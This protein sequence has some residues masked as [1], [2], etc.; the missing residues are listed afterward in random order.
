MA[1]RIVSPGVFTRE[2]DLSF[3]PTG[4]A[5]I[6]AA[7]VGPT[8]KGPS[9]VPTQVTSLSEFESIFGG[10]S[11]D[12]YTPYTV[13]EYLRSAGSV[14]VVRVGYLGGYKVSGFNLVISAS[15]VPATAG[16]HGVVATFL[17]AIN[18][19]G[20]SISGSLGSPTG[21]AAA[22]AGQASA[23]NFNLTINGA[24][25]T[26]SLSNLTIMES[27]TGVSGNF[28]AEKIPNLPTAKKIGTTDAPAYIYKH[29]RSNI[30]SSQ[31]RITNSGSLKIENFTL[32]AGYDFKSGAETITENNNSIDITITGNSD[33]SAAR[34]PHIQDQNGTNLFKI[35]TRADGTATNNHYVMIRDVKKPSN[36]NSSP[37]F[38][39]FGLQ[40]YDLSG[41]LMESFNKLNLD[42][43]S[44]N[45]IA[46]VIGDQFQD[47]DN[48]GNVTMYGNY[49]NLARH[50]RVGD[51]DEE[52]FKSSKSSQPMG[53]AAVL[54]VVKSTA[55]VPSASF[56]LKQV[57]G[58]VDVNTYVEECAYGFKI[59]ERFHLLSSL[60]TNKAFLAP[61]PKSE[62]SGNNTA[63]SLLNMK[64]F[65]TDT[66]SPSLTTLQSENT[67][68]AGATINL[69]ISSSVK[70]MKFAVPF[71][72]GFDGIDPA[73][74]LNSG[75]AI[76]STNSMGFDCSTTTASGSVAY[77][78]A[79][80]AVS[81]PDE[82]DINMLVTPGMVHSLHSP[83]TNHAINKVENRGDAFYV[84]DGSGYSANVN[85]AVND[86]ATLDTNF[87]ATY[88][89]WVK[90]DDPGRAGNMVWVPP[91][92][93]IPGVIAFT[94][95]VAHEWFAPAG[96][97]RG[98]LSSVRMAKK[99]LTHTD[100]DTLYEG[101]V[102]PIAT[103]P[104]Q[105]VVVF[106]QKTLQAKPSALDRINVRRLLIRLKKFI[107]SSSRFLVF[108]QNDSSTRS[109]FLNIVNPFLESVQANSGLSAF[110]VVMDDSNN[111]PD[112]I[113]RN[114]LVGQ[115]FIQPT[116]TAEFIVLDFTVLPT[117]AAFPE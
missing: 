92:V 110:K 76:N 14:K 42:P 11:S 111:T 94:D 10:F 57:D 117:G 68:F 97:N 104:G 99:K 115:I 35:Y 46:K 83:V 61:I 12:I 47:V 81:N 71:Q 9:F 19:V 27:G 88:F 96:L 28:F 49:P 66:T 74:S 84:M 43:D 6:D 2:R 16:F 26:A 93:V 116:R 86:I 38:S 65:G 107:A 109:R 34:T 15:K 72:H 55:P 85:T 48:E 50:I 23:S 98:G 25:A 75:N 69:S 36:S 53:F 58:K 108:E 103:F 1:E 21:M 101:R 18:N 20:G 8:L 91:S 22:Q 73:R 106:G 82:I 114:Q 32:A 100:R 78:R 67:N 44:P 17:P 7:I 39:E 105:G 77:K 37:E 54:D 24:N 3:L 30:S 51:Y 64:G 89:P 31:G 52:A 5:N 87:V 90:I 63:F 29:F 56:S 113:D 4:V 41:N 112:V 79:I 70:Q 95:R 33:A 40:L 62:T 60:D 59:D 102:N 13:N 80:N 45:F